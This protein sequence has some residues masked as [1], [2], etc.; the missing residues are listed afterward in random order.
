M[1][2]LQVAIGSY[3]QYYRSN[4]FNYFMNA[5]QIRQ[6]I[7]TGVFGR[8]IHYFETVDSTNSFAKRIA[9]DAEEGTVVIADEQ[10]AGRGRLGRR[11]E[12]PS[13]KN[14][15][16]S[17]I[18]KPDIKP[19]SLGIIPLYAGTAVA[20]FVR[21]RFGIQP[22]CKWPNDLLYGKKKFC[23]I[24]SEGIFRQDRC[25]A[26]VVGIG[27]NINQRRF[28]PDL[29]DAA[30]SLALVT[31]TD[32]PLEDLLT[33]LLTELEHWYRLLTERRMEKVRTAWLSF[34]PMIGTT[35]TIQTADS[36]ITGTAQGIDTDGALLLSTNGV[37]QKYFAGDVTLQN[38]R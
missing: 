21:Q 13:G 1:S 17:V 36:I 32:I 2:L 33:A 23:G 37:T 4:R 3:F 8:T 14:L 26:V 20:S 16:F 28:S 34:A 12:S 7:R 11:W 29:N 27:L 31:G 10:T 22:E 35:V 5:D 24:L 15:T 9:E 6:E 25:T 30:T 19:S 18:L 38:R